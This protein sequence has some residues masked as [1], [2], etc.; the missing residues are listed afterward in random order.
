[1]ERLTGRNEYG[2]AILC[3]RLSGIGIGLNDD[4]ERV[5]AYEDLGTVSELAEIKRK[6]ATGLLVELPCKVG[7]T[8]YGIAGQDIYVV[9]VQGF[10]VIYKDNK[11]YVFPAYY[12]PDGH[13]ESVK[14]WYATY[15]AALVALKEGR[16]EDE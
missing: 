14:S 5:A 3:E 11:P 12:I 7:D 4:V 8:I 2:D 16:G 6:M 9:V 15:K 1:M 10:E 13:I